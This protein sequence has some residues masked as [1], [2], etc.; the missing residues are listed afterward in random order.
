MIRTGGGCQDVERAQMHFE[1]IRKIPPRVVHVA[2]IDQ[3]RR[4]VQVAAPEA[5]SRM[6]Q[7]ALQERDGAIVFAGFACIN[8]QILE[9]GARRGWFGP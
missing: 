8:S 4:G 3:Q 5:F 7:G 6:G 9:R 2:D 1:R